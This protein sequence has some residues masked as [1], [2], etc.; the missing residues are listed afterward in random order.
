MGALLDSEVL[1]FHIIPINLIRFQQIDERKPVFFYC[2][3]N[4]LV[5]IGLVV[6]TSLITLH[7]FIFTD[8]RP[9]P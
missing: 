2:C 3:V 5:A 6:F 8:F 1:G 9:L 4:S 7:S